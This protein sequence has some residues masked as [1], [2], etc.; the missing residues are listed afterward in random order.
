MVLATT[1]AEYADRYLKAFATGGLVQA[2]WHTEK[3]GRQLACALGVL[4]DEVDH[5]ASGPRGGEVEGGVVDL[6]DGVAHGDARA[7]LERAA[8]QGVR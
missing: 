6:H 2:S 8:G 3:D 4:G 1:A 5:R 7:G